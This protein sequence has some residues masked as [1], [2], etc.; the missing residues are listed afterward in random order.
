MCFFILL[1]PNENWFENILRYHHIYGH[2]KNAEKNYPKVILNLMPLKAIVQST[3]NIVDGKTDL[4]NL[5]RV[6]LIRF[7][8]LVVQ[9]I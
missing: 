1:E 6:T 9:P 2:V 7:M 3:Y 5:Q 4:K 8:N